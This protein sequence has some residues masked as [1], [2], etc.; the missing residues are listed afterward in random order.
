V[1]RRDLTDAQ[2]VCHASA[3]SAGAKTASRAVLNTR[4]TRDLGGARATCSSTANLT[5]DVDCENADSAGQWGGNF[6][7]QCKRAALSPSSSMGTRFFE[8][9]DDDEDENVIATH[10]VP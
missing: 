8:D 10:V 5:A 1:H 7:E 6:C 9:E 2:S 4:L 3:G